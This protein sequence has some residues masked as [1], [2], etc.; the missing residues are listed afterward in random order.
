MKGYKILRI[1]QNKCAN[2]SLDTKVYLATSKKVPYCLAVKFFI[3]RDQV[4]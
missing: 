2:A 1:I 4:K 3:K